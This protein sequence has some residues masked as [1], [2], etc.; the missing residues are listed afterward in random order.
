MTEKRMPRENQHRKKRENYRK[1]LV[2]TL[3]IHFFHGNIKNRKSFADFLFF[4]LY[5][6][7]GWKRKAR[8]SEDR[9]AAKEKKNDDP[10]G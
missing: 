3:Q 6:G 8:K 1:T 9:K 5:R 10:G 7:A 4:M 2:C